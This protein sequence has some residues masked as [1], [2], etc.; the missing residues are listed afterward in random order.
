MKF[1]YIFYYNIV[2]QCSYLR[3]NE[4]FCEEIGWIDSKLLSESMTFLN[5]LIGKFADINLFGEKYRD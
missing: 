4:S 3:N 2:Q 5:E 1:K